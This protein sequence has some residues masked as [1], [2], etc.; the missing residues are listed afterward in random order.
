MLD[1]KYDARSVTPSKY[2]KSQIKAFQNVLTGAAQT[3]KISKPKQAHYKAQGYTIKNGRIVVPVAA[4]EKV[5]GTHGDFRVKTVGEFGSI[6]RIDAGMSK[7]DVMLWQQQLLE[8]KVKLRKGESIY[9]QFYGNN[10]YQTFQNFEQLL[11]YLQMYTT[12]DEVE[13][14]GTPEDHMNLIENI[15]IYRIDRDSTKPPRISESPEAIAARRAH[16]AEKRQRYLDRM[17]PEQTA[18]YNT[19]RADDER[20]RRESQKKKLSPEQIEAQKQKARERAKKSYGAR[21]GRNGKKG[22]SGN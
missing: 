22:T 19:K 9:F 17:S 12:V 21:S 5:S 16:R 15:V 4:N 7:T 18:R 2:L 20:K 8:R 13:R 1:K 6:T 14:K 10:S 3:V 11:F